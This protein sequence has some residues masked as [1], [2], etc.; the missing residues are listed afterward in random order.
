MLTT[1][2]TAMMIIAMALGC[3]ALSVVIIWNVYLNVKRRKM[4]IH[5]HQFR[6]DGEIDMDIEELM[7]AAADGRVYLLEE[8]A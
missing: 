2:A 5:A 7:N 4:S 8:D 1:T 6:F 3:I